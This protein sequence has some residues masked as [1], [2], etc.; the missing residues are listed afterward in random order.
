MDLPY[1]K[2]EN[3]EPPKAREFRYRGVSY[4]K[5][6]T[7]AKE[8]VSVIELADTLTAGSGLRRHC[9]LPNHEDRTPSFVLY[10][11]TQSFFCFG[12]LHGGDVVDLYRLAK[13]YDELD[14]HVAAADLLLEFGHEIPQRPP[15]WFR[16]QHRQKRTRDLVEEAQLEALTRRLWDYVFE[17]IVKEIEDEH[18]RK[19]L[20]KRLWP[21][22]EANARYL[23]A[24]RRGDTK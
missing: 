7:A 9:P 14:A 16:K 21:K 6:I 23:L 4:V 19:A 8:A 12:C 2:V 15:A 13:G 24:E 10:P 5:P 1:H 17:P 11:E 18:D 3:Q 22:I 20:A